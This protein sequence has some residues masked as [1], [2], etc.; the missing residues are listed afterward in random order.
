MARC[1]AL[2]VAG[3]ICSYTGRY[4]EAQRHLHEGLAIARYRHDRRMIA[5]IQNYLALA[6]LGLGDRAAAMVH[7]GEA[8]D[9]ARELGDKREISAASNA[10]AQLKRL[11]GD[12][13]GA[14][15]LYEQ[16]VTLAH[17]LR[18][19]EMVAI[20]M[21]GLSMVAIGRG[22]A[23]QA[24]DLLREALAIASETGSRTAG[25]TALEVS[26]GLAA[27][28]KEWELSA[29]LYGA[30]EAQTLRTGIKR[31]PADEAFLQPLLAQTREALGESR[32]TLADASGR[33]MPFQQ[34]MAEAGAWLA[35]GATGG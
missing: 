16:A 19:P 4:E 2:W 30:A 10:L 13:D 17:E 25:Q 31:D 27:L 5:T 9:L 28:Q 15:L 24:R 21:L 32:F 35:P 26:A 22:L 1:K 29:N 34:A 3:Q 6:A 18:D 12:L 11:D 8:L 20:G 33:A 7:C 14:E 23:T